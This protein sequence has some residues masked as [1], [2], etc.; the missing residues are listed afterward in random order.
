VKLD[1]V[2]RQIGVLYTVP[3]LTLLEEERERGAVD[4]CRATAARLE[5]AIPRARLGGNVP[6]RA[7]DV[8]GRG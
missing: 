2:T 4:R 5:A 6:T 7:A 1:D 3:F 8:C